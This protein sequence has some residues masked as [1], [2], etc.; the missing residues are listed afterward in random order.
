MPILDATGP[1]AEGESRVL[2]AFLQTQSSDARA[3]KWVYRGANAPI[4]FIWPEGGIG[5]ELCEWLDS[6]QAQWVAE[7]DRF[8]EEIESEIEKRKLVQFS[9]GGRNSRC[10]VEV[11]VTKVPG[12]SDKKKATDEL[13]QFMVE[14]E[15]NHKKE[16]YRGN[17]IAETSK[18][19]LPSSLSIFVARMIFYGFLGQ[20]LGVV[21]KS[22]S[23]FDGGHPAESNSAIRSLEQALKAKTVI[24]AESYV[25]EKRRLSLSELWLV[26]HYSSLLESLMR[27]LLN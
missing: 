24:K 10:T 1:K 22:A 5:I 12:Q 7:R 11:L 2:K 4:D 26:L 16:I 6:Q 21:V 25:A 15:R 18:G 3:G 17:M 8:R 9:P 27:L 13:I 19:L 20:N 14:F 23:V